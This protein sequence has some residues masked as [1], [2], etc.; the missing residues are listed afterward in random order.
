[1]RIDRGG[2]RA[3]RTIRGE[4]PRRAIDELAY[5]LPRIGQARAMRGTVFSTNVTVWAARM[6]RLGWTS[7]VRSASFL[8]ADP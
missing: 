6:L 2:E 8:A 3:R 1:M 5:A 7:A 4:R